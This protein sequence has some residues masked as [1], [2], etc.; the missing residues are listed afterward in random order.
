MIYGYLWRLW[1]WIIYGLSWLLQPFSVG[2]SIFRYLARWERYQP[3]Q[4][5]TWV[6]FPV[7]SCAK[8]WDQNIQKPCK[9][10]KKNHTPCTSIHMQSP[11]FTEILEREDIKGPIRPTTGKILRSAQLGGPVR[12]WRNFEYPHQLDEMTATEMPR[13]PPYRQLQHSWKSDRKS[14]CY[15]YF[16]LLFIQLSDWR[17]QTG[18]ERRC[19]GTFEWSNLSRE[20]P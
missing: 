14:K 10:T 11:N 17:S 5:G 1:P 2:A 13:P 18:R 19:G 20:P 3:R 15:C 8:F 9:T 4:S 7:R 16:L 6:G 12:G